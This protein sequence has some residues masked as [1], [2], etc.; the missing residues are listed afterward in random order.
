[1]EP[2]TLKPLNQD[3]SVEN[4]FLEKERALESAAYLSANYSI[5]KKFAVDLGLRYSMFM[6][7]GEQT[8]YEYEEG[9]PKIKVPSGIPFNMATMK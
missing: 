7:L 6:A 9:A 4:N 1:M 5:T 8:Q 3:S 2:G